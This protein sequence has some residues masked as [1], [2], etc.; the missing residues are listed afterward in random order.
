MVGGS[1]NYLP[2]PTFERATFTYTIS[3][4]L[5]GTSTATVTV[6]RNDHAS[7][8]G[9]TKNQ[10]ETVDVPGVVDTAT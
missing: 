8:L 5:G 2:D 4:G 10:T 1:L 7:Q 6:T 3:D 9:A